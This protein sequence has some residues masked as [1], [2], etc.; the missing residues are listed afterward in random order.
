MRLV[1][2]SATRTFLLTDEHPSRFLMTDCHDSER[3]VPQCK[4]SDNLGSIGLLEGEIHVVLDVRLFPRTSRR[5]VCQTSTIA[6]AMVS[7]S[8]QK[9]G[10]AFPALC[11]R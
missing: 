10:K 2:G 4:V 8:L 5:R 9:S 1:Q 11:Y 3:I 7:E 6:I